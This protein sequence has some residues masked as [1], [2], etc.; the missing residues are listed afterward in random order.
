MFN[1]LTKT[2]TVIAK[3]SDFI[4]W[5]KI[6]DY[7]VILGRKNIILYSLKLKTISYE[8]NID[9]PNDKYKWFKIYFDSLLY[10]YSKIEETMYTVKL[11]QLKKVWSCCNTKEIYLDDKYVYIF[12][13]DNQMVC[14][15]KDANLLL[16][17][18]T[19]ENIMD[20][21][22]ELN[23]KRELLLGLRNISVIE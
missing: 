15:D 7:L 14:I 2:K 21:N 12:T 10:I 11:G 1:I 20:T 16:K 17:P 8:N 4:N 6:N 19:K 23:D 22:L 13:E 18:V 9:H 5:K 3:C